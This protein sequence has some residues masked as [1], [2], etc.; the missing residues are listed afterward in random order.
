MLI[1]IQSLRSI[2]NIIFTPT[3]LK[4]TKSLNTMASQLAEYA[5]RGPG[6]FY[7][8][9]C[10][11]TDYPLIEPLAQNGRVELSSLDG[12][13]YSLTIGIEQIQLEQDTGKSLHDVYPGE[14]LLDLNRA[15]T[16]LMEIV[17]KPDLRSSKEAGIMVKKLQQLLRA[18]DSSDGNMEEVILLQ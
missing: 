3:Y 8:K 13:D 2:A 15:G 6:L 10:S 18:V 4:A 11:L 1:S 7:Y 16:G 5:S 12:L 14:T 17:T 9:Y